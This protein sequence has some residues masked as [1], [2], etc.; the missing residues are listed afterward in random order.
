MGDWGL[1]SVGESNTAKASFRV[2][3]FH[4]KVNHQPSNRRSLRSV[5][6]SQL[7]VKGSKD[8]L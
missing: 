2:S 4:E 8:N 3:G 6:F 1:N 5:S 7:E